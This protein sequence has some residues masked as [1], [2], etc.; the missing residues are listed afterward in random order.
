MTE[1]ARLSSS[2][3]DDMAIVALATPP[4]QSAA[5]LYPD[6]DEA[7]RAKLRARLKQLSRQEWPTSMR[8]DPKLRRGYTLRQCFRLASALALLDA[9]LGPSKAVAIASANELAIIREMVAGI[10]SGSELSA[11][12][13][14]AVCIADD[15]WGL[16]DEQAVKDCQPL[17]LRWLPRD[18]LYDLWSATDLNCP[19]QRILLDFASV[20]QRVWA[21][22][23]ARRLLP[24][25]ELER[26]R[27]EIQARED[28]PGYQAAQGR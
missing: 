14:V 17:H 8:K 12:G 9:Q 21:W 25:D 20:A 3:L 1:P 16:V 24:G 23:S 11:G 2:H 13:K 26:L 28:E 6:L 15:L 7:T 18:N 19:G 5:C 4:G 22:I 27:A 10:G